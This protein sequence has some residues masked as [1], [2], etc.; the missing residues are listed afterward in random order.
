MNPKFIVDTKIIDDYI[1]EQTINYDFEGYI[2]QAS[3][4]IINTRDLQVR[5]VLIKLGWTPPLDEKIKAI[6]ENL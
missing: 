4:Q 1:I 5:E 6:Y 3:R 2:K